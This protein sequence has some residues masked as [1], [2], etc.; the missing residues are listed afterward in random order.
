M[1]VSKPILVLNPDL[2]RKALA[3]EFAIDGRIQ[4]RDVLI[5]QSASQIADLL[6]NETPWGISWQAGNDG[7]HK[8][9]REEAVAMT[10]NQWQEIYAKLGAAASAGA[11]AFIYTQYQTYDAQLDGW[12]LDPRQDQLV[13]DINSTVML[14]LVREVT[15]MSQIL[16]S[17][18]Q[19]TLYGQQQFLGLHQDVSDQGWLIAYVLS[20]APADW[21]QDWGGYLNFFDDAG[22]IIHGYRPRFNALTMFRIPRDHN[23]SYVPG[24]APNGRFAISGWFRDR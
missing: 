2:D 5:A 12:S 4:I 20:F 14:D 13:N 8:L 11:F 3:A 15:G 17:D 6:T 24:F 21:R 10:Q 1:N 7:P 16:W 23:V 19:A 22:D 18:A 9:R